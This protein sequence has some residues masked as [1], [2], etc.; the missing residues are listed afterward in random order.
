MTKKKMI[1]KFRYKLFILTIILDK[2][3]L[4]C[5]KQKA[6]EKV[7][8]MRLILCGGGSGKQNILA[9]AKLN[10]IIDNSKKILYVPLAMNEEEHPYDGCY[11]WITKELALVEKSGIEMV[12][13]FEQLAS[14]DY[15][16]YGAIFIGGGNTYK[17]LK[18]LK[19]SGAFEKIRDY[20]NSNGIVI[21]GSAGAVIFGKDI[22][23]ISK[24]DP[25]DVELQDTLGFDI[26]DGIS[27]FPHYTNFRS[28][29]TEEENI[30]KQNEYSEFMVD[31]S[32]NNG[33]VIAI[34]EEDFIFISDGD[35]EV[36]GTRP[37]YE[38]TNGEK[39]K[40]EIND[41]QKNISR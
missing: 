40:Y 33:K 30:Q 18:G 26:L 8:N 35:I 9:N 41:N 29:Y 15:S 14:I 11:E 38:F 22:N 23:I 3:M 32:I 2:N 19:E 6:K 7:K 10:E 20:I 25:N 34:P 17:L 4:K 27:I 16:I 31:Y 24:M 13:T 39:T 12:R 5:N 21:G 28:K 36:I 1:T 37:Y